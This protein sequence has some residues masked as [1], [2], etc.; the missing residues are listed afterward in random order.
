MVVSDRFAR[1]LVVPLLVSALLA[2]CGGDADE[3]LDLGEVGEHDELAL[4]PRALSG[5]EVRV[6]VM[7]ANISSGNYQSYDPGHGTRIFQGT[8]PDIVLIQEFNYGDN[9]ATAIRGWVDGTFGSSFAYYREGGA[10]I[11]NGVISRYPILASG[12]WDDTRVSNR[13]FAWARIDVPGPVDLWAISVHLL[14]SSSTE[15]NLEAQQLVAKIDTLVPDGDYVVVAGDLNTSSRSESAISTLSQVVTTSGPHPVDE[16]NNGNT[17]ASRAKP[18]DWVLASPNLNVKRVATVIGA[19][20]YANG[21]VV[22]TRVYSPLSELSPALSGDSGAT[23]MQHMAVIKDFALPA[24]G[25][26]P[27]P[28]VTVTAPNGGESW[29]A[30]SVHDVTWTS[31]DVTSVKVEYTLDGGSSWTTLS[32]S[33]PAANGRIAW[34]V[35][36]TATTSAKVRVTSTTS[37]TVTD[38][39]NGAFA[40]TTSS[41]GSGSISAESESNNGSS[42]ADGP[43]G[44]GK[45]VSGAISSSTDQD[46]FLFTANTSGTVTISVTV[47]GSADLDWYL[48]RAGSSSYLT[49]GYTVNNPETKSYTLYSAGTYY[50]KVVGYGGDTSSYTLEVAAAASMIDP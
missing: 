9:S 44:N 45:E 14:T 12:E 39:S 40:I 6:R 26:T 48:Y 33:V 24:D 29:S 22:D 11:P 2:G 23:N 42:T 36:S 20:T 17:N 34:T 43:L 37:A 3:K 38:A 28:T 16:N 27:T 46:W 21:L 32:S 25:T 8:D 31:N 19:S 30:G 47:P 4:A 7:A 13:D 18:Y 35:P 1:F 49:R 15:R 10:Q 41:G 5:D 50:V